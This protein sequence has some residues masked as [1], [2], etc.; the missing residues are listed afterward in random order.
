M[1]V[2]DEYDFFAHVYLNAINEKV[3]DFMDVEEYRLDSIPRKYCGIIFVIGC[4]ISSYI[5]T[6]N[7]I[8]VVSQPFF[9]T[10]ALDARNNNNRVSPRC[11]LLR[12]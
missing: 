9:Q 10:D 4:E 7:G 1:I 2:D 11:E 5:C 8:D 12:I 6:V 3:S